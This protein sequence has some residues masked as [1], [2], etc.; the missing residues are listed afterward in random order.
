M[1]TVRD[2]QTMS[3]RIAGHQ[4]IM[5]RITDHERSFRRDGK[6]IHDFLKHLRMGFTARLIGRTGRVKVDP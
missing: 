5:C 2:R 6:L 3:P 1:R 4:Q